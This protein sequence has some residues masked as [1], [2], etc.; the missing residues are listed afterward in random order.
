MAN[1]FHDIEGVELLNKPF[2]KRDLGLKLRDL[3]GAR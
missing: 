2:R 3:L 1:D